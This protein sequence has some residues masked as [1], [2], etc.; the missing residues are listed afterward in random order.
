MTNSRY[1]VGPSVVPSLRPV[2]QLIDK[3][4]GDGAKLRKN[5][6]DRDHGA[7]QAESRRG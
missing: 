2:K 6:S 1:A 7:Q 3:P 5:P 4:T